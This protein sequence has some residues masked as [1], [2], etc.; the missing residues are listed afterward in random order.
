VSKPK[1]I[2][3][4]V[5]DLYDVASPRSSGQ[6]QRMM[7]NVAA[8]HLADRWTSSARLHRS[9]SRARL[10]YRAS[11]ARRPPS[12]ESATARLPTA[13]SGTEAP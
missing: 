3:M 11:L 8:A 9:A 13:W 4:H 2:A 1:V 12:D 7:S 5:F 10:P 6:R